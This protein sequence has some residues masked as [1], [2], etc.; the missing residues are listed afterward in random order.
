M[1]LNDKEG[2]LM[3]PFLTAFELA[4]KKS[5][6][7]SWNSGTKIIAKYNTDYESENCLEEDDPN[8]EEFWAC[9]VKVEKIIH[10]AEIDKLSISPEGSYFEITYHNIPDHYEPAFPQAE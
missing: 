6:V 5:L 2:E 1:W 9:C 3:G 10:L 7:L 8:Y 4:P